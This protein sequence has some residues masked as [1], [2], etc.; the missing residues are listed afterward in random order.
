MPLFGAHMSAAGEP[1]NALLEAAGFH[2]EACQLFTKSNR[3]WQAGA[4]TP[5]MAS[6]FKEVRAE[7]GIQ[8]AVAHAAYLLNLATKDD[9]LRA[10]SVAALV[11]EMQ[12]AE[13]LGLD[14]LVLHPGA[15]QD[16]DEASALA[17]VSAAL[18]E[19]HHTV[20]P[21]RVQLLLETTAGQG[22]SVGHRFEHLAAI[23]HGMRTAGRLGFCLDTCHVFAAGYEL[24][25]RRSYLATLRKFDRLLGLPRLR[26]L[27]LNDS[28]K[29]LGSRVDRH[30]HL[31]HGCL[32]LEAF[33]LIVN[34]RRLA[35]RPMIL[36]TPK[37]DSN[38]EA[39]DAVNL[40]TLRGLVEGKRPRAGKQLVNR[41]RVG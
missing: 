39:W 13:K 25:P 30:A 17:L 16:D 14:Y 9:A 34:D 37:G 4:L 38:G 8:V 21:I 26:M 36:E 24:S 32:G 40:R 41:P 6:R 5:A 10:K 23:T 19:V 7:K 28:V 31:G 22:R 29:P 20:G 12:R 33:A 15:A 11:I 27:H 2:M 1:A 18:D 35:D 3:Q